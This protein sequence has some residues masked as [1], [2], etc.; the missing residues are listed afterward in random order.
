M[1]T[2]RALAPVAALGVLVA[3]LSGCAALRNEWSGKHGGPDVDGEVRAAVS[4]ALPDATGVAVR[5]QKNGFAQEMTVAITFP[6][7]TFEAEALL[8]TA[9]AVCGAVD[10]TDTVFVEVADAPTGH[11]L[12]LAPLVAGTPLDT[13]Y[14]P[15]AVRI[16]V[17]DDCPAL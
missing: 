14:D 7:A 6:S 11:P 2:R 13:P 10:R 16:E 5:S 9:R 4:G 8:A 12:D 17:T 1:R 3:A 15:T